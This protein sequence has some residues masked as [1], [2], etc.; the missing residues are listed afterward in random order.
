VTGLTISATSQACFLDWEP[1]PGI[2]TYR[3]RAAWDPYGYWSPVATTGQTQYETPLP[4][5]VDLTRLFRVTAI[6]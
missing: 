6:Q 3:I 4:A 1:M 2:A 5:G